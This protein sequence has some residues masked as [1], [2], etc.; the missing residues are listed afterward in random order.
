MN[1]PPEPR[2]SAPHRAGVVLRRLFGS[3]ALVYA[4][5]VAVAVFVTVRR[6]SSSST[7]T[8]FKIFR[9]SFWHLVDDIN[10]Y[11]H[12]PAEQGAAAVDLFKYSPTAAMLFMPIAL[13]PYWLA[14]LMWSVVS[15]LAMCLVLERLLGRERGRVAQ[16]LLL[17]EV[18]ATLEAV[19]SNALITVLM[20]AGFIALEE[21]RQLR[22]AIAIVTATALKIYPA[23]TLVLALFHPRRW[24]FA[25]VTAGVA[26]IELLMPLLVTPPS[27]LVQQYRWW[28]ATETYDASDLAFGE[29]VMKVMRQWFHLTWPNW[30]VQLLATLVLLTPLL[31]RRE[32]WGDASFR[33]TA[34]ASLL[35]F[36]VIF[37]HQ[38]ERPSFVIAVTGAVI[39]YLTSPRG[40]LR[41]VPTALSVLG[42]QSPPL[43]ACWI[44]IQ[45]D[46]WAGAGRADRSRSRTAPPALQTAGSTAPGTPACG[47]AGSGRATGPPPTDG[48]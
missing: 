43:L 37:N 48:T 24:R 1:G 33:R 34:L 40:W 41:R 29:S 27:T 17:P 4:L 16:W 39:W 11:A 26:L 47:P 18:F 42:L 22:A 46:L 20:I 12:Y 5:Y 2:A 25:A 15:A 3:R 44:L 32:R 10:L 7:H 6:G 28:F 21:R 13:P 36:A 23:A 35:V 38:A 45:R 8:T 14:M 9:Q 30:P 19:Q 31:L